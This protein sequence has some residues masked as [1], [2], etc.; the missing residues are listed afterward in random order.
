M[1]DIGRLPLVAGLFLF[2]FLTWRDLSMTEQ[3]SHLLLR[4]VF[5]QYTSV[6]HEKFPHV[7]VEGDNYPPPAMRSLLAQGLSVLKLALIAMVYAC[8]M[9]FFISNAIEGQ[10]IS[11]GAFEISFN[12]VPVWSKLETGRIP[13][14]AEMFQIIEN[15][16]RFGQSQTT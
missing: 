1:A 2:V 13:S 16:M 8:L 14:A 15:H 12:D 9:I 11:T 3:S 7:A 4:R 10:L 6:L 5:E